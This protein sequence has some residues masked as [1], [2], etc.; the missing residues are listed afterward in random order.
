G[1]ALLTPGWTSYDHR[2]QYQTYDVTALL[3]EGENVLGA[4]LG[5][6]WF[7]GYLGNKGFRNVYGDRLA[8]LAQLQITYADGRVELV[9]SD[10]AWRASTGPILMSDL[11]LGETYDARLE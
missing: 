7:R 3:R 9:G 1:E 11:Y 5:D 8:L 2:L 10:E 4:M 6:G